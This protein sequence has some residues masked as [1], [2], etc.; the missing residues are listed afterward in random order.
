M[1]FRLF[2]FALLSVTLL[3]SACSKEGCTDIDSV[4]YDPE[5]KDDDGS[6]Q[7]AGQIV[8]W[9]GQSTA[10]G[11]V[12][13]GANSLL[14]YIDGSLVGSTSTS[15]F[16]SSA[17][18]CGD[19]SSITAEADLGDVKSLAGVYSVRDQTGWEYWTGVVNFTANDCRTIELLW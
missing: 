18:D 11:L 7:Y 2:L 1:K 15:A 17:P 10:Q 14:F 8:F 16:W 3:F 19:N 6:C 5:A 9:Y 4:N 13:D 12:N